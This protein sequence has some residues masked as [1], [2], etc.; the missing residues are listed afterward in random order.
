MLPARTTRPF[1]M[2]TVPSQ[3]SPS[4]VKSSLNRSRT[5]FSVRSGSAYSVAG[6][7]ADLVARLGQEHLGGLPQREPA[8]HVDQ[9][10]GHEV[11]GVEDLRHWYDEWQQVLLKKC[12]Q[13]PTE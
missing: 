13:T 9:R 3:I 2:I 10:A 4:S 5:I 7:D 6:A 11:E 12:R 8:G 1:S